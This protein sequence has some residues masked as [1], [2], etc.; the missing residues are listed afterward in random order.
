MGEGVSHNLV[1]LSKLPFD[2]LGFII[3]INSETILVL[4]HNFFEVLD[5]IQGFFDC[6]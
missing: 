2:G 6:L 5:R 3:F 1:F 4:T